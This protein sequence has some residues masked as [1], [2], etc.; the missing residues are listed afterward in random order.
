MME[1]GDFQPPKLEKE[2]KKVKQ[3]WRFV[4]T[5]KPED[6]KPRKLWRLMEKNRKLGTHLGP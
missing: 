2:I 4:S 6:E 3:L 1:I 5:W